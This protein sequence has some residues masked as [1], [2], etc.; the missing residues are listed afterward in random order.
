MLKAK[1]SLSSPE[2]ME[3]DGEEETPRSP[4]WLQTTNNVGRIQRY[5][6]R[7]SSLF[8]NSV[9][10]IIVLL[11]LAILSMV[12]VIPNVID[13]S[14]NVF[15][16]NLVRRSWDSINLI[17]VLVALAF[18]FLSRNV[19]NDEKVSY[20]RS[21]SELSTG[22]P[23]ITSPSSSTPHQW[24]DFPDQSMSSTTGLRRQKTSISYPDLRELSPPWDHGAVDPWR[25][26]DDTH[27]NYYKVL[28]SNRNY[29]R[30][31]SRR[32]QDS[33]N[34]GVVDVNA[35][36]GVSQDSL[37][38][39]AQKP[40]VAEERLYIPPPQPMPPPSLPAQPPI[41][42]VKK[43]MKTKRRARSSEPRKVLSPVIDPL[44]EPSSPP[45]VKQLTERKTNGGNA[46]KEFFTS[47]YHKKKKKR[48][49]ERSFD[50]LQS[51]LHHSRP[52]ATR[53]Q[54]PPT[55]PTPPPPPHPPS[56]LHKLFPTKKEKQKIITSAA[57]PPPVPHTSPPPPP[58]PTSTASLTRRPTRSQSAPFLTDN[59]GVPSMLGKF[60]SIE[61]SSSGGDSP[62]KQVPPPPPPLPPFKVPDWEF[63]VQG[64]FVNLQSGVSSRSVSPIGD[65]AQSPSSVV[66]ATVAPPLFCPSPDVDTKADNFIE[67]FRARLQLERMSKLGPGPDSGPGES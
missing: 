1:P 30:Q 47:F 4:F 13:F 58:P 26:S 20:D 37:Y 22:A 45:P 64:D 51:L 35:F 19:N 9:V 34:Q 54:L 44:P 46:T 53:F 33:G 67:S 49:K 60:N 18:G 52:P 32:E 41:D 40:A 8:F 27:L 25:F 65:E 38:T 48:Q 14:S 28:E 2:F 12:F 6:R 55:S 17:L 11:L 16:P 36:G 42:T 15:K 61:D 66:D 29:L 10:L 59:P 50:D 57:L 21:L 62:M 39:P 5:R 7:L 31:R 63:A 24:Y 3:E 56:V 23:M 43:K